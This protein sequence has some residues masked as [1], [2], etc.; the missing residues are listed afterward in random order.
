[1][2]Q[3]T[4]ASA[5]LRARIRRLS[6]EQL[7]E[8][9]GQTLAL[10]YKVPLDESPVQ[11]IVVNHIAEELVTRGVA[12][13]DC[14]YCPEGHHDVVVCDLT[15]PNRYTEAADLIMEAIQHVR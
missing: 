11:M 10:F 13:T 5:A 9:H 12:M 8:L 4:K 6:T 14:C 1:M 7:I 15:V 2:R 3:K